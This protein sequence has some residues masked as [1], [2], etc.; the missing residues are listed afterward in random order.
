MLAIRFL[1][2]PAS[3]GDD[4]FGFTRYFKKQ[5]NIKILFAIRMIDKEE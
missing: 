1:L 2:L 4:I 5:Y 3:M